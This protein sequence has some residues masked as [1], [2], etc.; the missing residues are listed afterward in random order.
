MGVTK[1]EFLVQLGN[2]K[3][4]GTAVPPWLSSSFWHRIQLESSSGPWWDDTGSW[5]AQTSGLPWGP[6]ERQ[7]LKSA[8]R[9]NDTGRTV[10]RRRRRLTRPRRDLKTCLISCRWALLLLVTMLMIVS[11][12][13][14]EHTH[15]VVG[16]WLGGEELTRYYTHITADKNN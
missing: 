10:Q 16:D 7:R 11:S 2:I 12:S 8:R 15:R 13:V 5:R 4:R 14:P 1:R 9:R 3:G 6:A